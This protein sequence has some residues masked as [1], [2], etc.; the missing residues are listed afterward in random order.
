MGHLK[1]SKKMKQSKCTR[2]ELWSSH[3]RQ[4]GFHCK[5]EYKHKH[6][7]QLSLRTIHPSYICM[8]ITII[9]ANKNGAGGEYP[10]LIEN[11]ASR[12]SSW[13]DRSDHL[14]GRYASSR[15]VRR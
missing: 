9:R 1:T 2:L 15:Q 8:G 11:L 12:I 13:E 10:E 5:R 3:R 4:T 6:Q 7:A 14:A